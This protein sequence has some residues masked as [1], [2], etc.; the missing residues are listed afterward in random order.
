MGRLYE[1]LKEYSAGDY[2]A[3]HM[4]GHKRNAFGNMPKEIAEI[5]ITEI[6]GFDNLHQAEGIIKELQEEA[7]KIYGAEETFYL[8][9][10]STCGILCAI[11]AALPYGGHI[12][13]ARNCH[14]STY[15]AAYLKN[16]T[17]SYLYPEINAEYDIAEAVSPKQ[18][19]R[20]LEKDRSIQAVFLVSPTYEGRI[21][22]VAAIADIVHARGIPLIVDEA[23]GA[24]LGMSEHF[25]QNSCR[26]GADLVI[27]SVHKTLPAMTQ[28]ALLHV[29][30]SRV[31]RD[32]IGRFLHIYQSSS[33]SYVLMGS[34]DN[35]MQ[36]IQDQGD[37]LFESFYRNYCWL[38]Q[39]LTA[40]EHL[41]FLPADKI[42]QDIG[43]LVISSKETGLSGQQVFDIL[44]HQYHLQLEMAAG[45]YC[46]AM[47]TVGDKWEAYE[48]LSDALL[49]IDNGIETGRFQKYESNNIHVK[50]CTAK[51]D[52]ADTHKRKED[53]TA[54][55]LPFA[56]AW[57]QKSELVPLE[58]A[59]GRY[60]GEFINL[61]P[62]GTPLLVPGEI[63]STTQYLQIREYLAQ[64]LTVCG[65]DIN[66]PF[67]V[68]VLK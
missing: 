49:E 51:V 13:M 12:L 1:K 31:D 32:R 4:P 55:A 10:G 2:Y 6:D 33:P 52:A 21:A 19:A 20:A 38:L 67:L 27:H 26:L 64:G 56:L 36:L 61:Y 14:K 47:F 25:A 41:Q 24:H 45:S 28:T 34:I 42:R 8:V 59:I 48:R 22:D 58:E 37:V 17:I 29:N 54:E 46:L 7:S 57:D 62:P 16:L 63:L 60:V 3:Y 39:S 35:A 15:H 50:D 11:S 30:G 23:H 5:D 65:I 40:C 66:P 68:K 18:V 43:K 9:N 44:L 53:N